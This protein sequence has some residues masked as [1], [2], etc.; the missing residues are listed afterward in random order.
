MQSQR[1]KF[2]QLIEAG[3]QTDQMG[4]KLRVLANEIDILRSESGDKEIKLVH[5]RAAHRRDDREGRAEADINKR[6]LVLR[7][8]AMDRRAGERD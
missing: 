5:A 7:R 6:T 1:N 2:A 8:A 4:E 3:K